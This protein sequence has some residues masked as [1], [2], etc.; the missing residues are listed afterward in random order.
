M[1]DSS[2]GELSGTRPNMAEKRDKDLVPAASGRIETRDE[3]VVAIFE[4]APAS[5][6]Y[7]EHRRVSDMTPVAA[8]AFKRRAEAD[9]KI[10]IVPARHRTYRALIGSAVLVF[11]GWIAVKK[12]ESK[13][14]SSVLVAVAL[15]AGAVFA[16]REF[17]K[18]KKPE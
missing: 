15:A 11:I 1:F 2:R 12:L 18:K 8:D 14:L 4:V 10:V 17:S 9:E 3:K 5:S 6:T 7:F 16:V 13:D